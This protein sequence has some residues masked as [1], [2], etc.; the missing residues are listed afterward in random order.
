MIFMRK[1]GFEKRIK[2]YWK[3]EFWRVKVR[4]NEVI[5]YIVTCSLLNLL[6]KPTDCLNNLLKICYYAGARE[7]I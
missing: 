2:S 1:F 6:L 4:V 5:M 7:F 3:F